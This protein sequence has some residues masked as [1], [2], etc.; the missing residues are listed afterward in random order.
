MDFIVEGRKKNQLDMKFSCEGYVGPYEYKARDGPFFC[1]AG[2]NIGSVL[3]DGSISAC[4]NIDRAFV[5]GTIYSDDF[6]T[7]WQTKFQ[8]LRDRSW[9]KQGSCAVCKDY[10]DCQGNGF[11]LWHGKKKEVLVCHKDKLIP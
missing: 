1:R 8:A 5:Q 11:H 10:R 7:T 2:I 3:I 6:F 9:T 4:P